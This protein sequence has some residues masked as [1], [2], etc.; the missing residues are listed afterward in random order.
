MP[1]WGC[2]FIYSVLDIT[3]L[4]CTCPES[5]WNP[6]HGGFS[7]ILCSEGTKNT[8][9]ASGGVTRSVA[10]RTSH[11][12]PLLSHRLHGPTGLQLQ[13]THTFKVKVMKN[14]LITKCKTLLGTGSCVTVQV[15]MPEKQ[16]LTV[17]IFV[18]LMTG[19]CSH[20]SH[21]FLFWFR[22]PPY[23]ESQ[24]PRNFA[25]G[26]F[27][28]FWWWQVIVI[29]G[30]GACSLLTPVRCLVCLWVRH[31]SPWILRRKKWSWVVGSLIKIKIYDQ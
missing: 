1:S 11:L 25:R 20:S 6:A 14:S 9:Y 30:S 24:G 3:C 27:Q 7:W 21:S 18:I 10:T 28:V 26:E 2:T 13:N 23:L 4:P 22:S 15:T 5:C 17:V 29:Q 31:I 19:S 8:L 12:S 16:A